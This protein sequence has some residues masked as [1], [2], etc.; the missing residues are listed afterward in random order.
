MI[1]SEAKR[2]FEIRCYYWWISEFEKE[3][4]ASFPNLRLFK[5]GYGW[6]LHY[7]MQKLEPRDQL[8]LAHAR[9]K[10]GSAY[11]KAS[12]ETMTEEE[13]RL[14]DSFYQFAIEPSGLEVEIKARKQAGEKI[15]LGTKRNLRKAA[16]SKFVDAF[17]S[18]C[19]DMNLGEE[20]D[21][22]FHMKCCGWIISTQLYFGRSQP[23]INY[24]HMI[25]SETRIAHPQNPQITGPAMTL[26]P[27]VVWLVHQWDDI[28]EEDVDAVC[29]ALVKQAGFFFEVAPKLL[30][31][32]EFDKM[33]P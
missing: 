9:C 21:P 14:L 26:S 2:E 22:L 19:F 16:V 5:S 7:F 24:R 29:N 15:K 12:A 32:L 30:A 25:V 4:N 28:V 33:V 1:L 20:W 17:G 10:R 8:V 31:G 23:L 13:T 3:I 27:G 18:Q 6:K 11:L